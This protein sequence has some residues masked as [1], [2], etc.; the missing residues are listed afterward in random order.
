MYELGL[1]FATSKESVVDC[2]IRLL[3]QAYDAQGSRPT[4]TNTGCPDFGNPKALLKD[5][6]GEYP[7]KYACTSCEP[8]SFE[9]VEADPEP[10]AKRCENEWVR[11]NG[12][13]WDEVF[14]FIY[15][16]TNVRSHYCDRQK[17]LLITTETG[18]VW[19]AHPGYYIIIEPGGEITARFAL[20]KCDDPEPEV[21]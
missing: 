1:K 2:A 7:D 9:P 10:E 13:N 4:C 20:D 11:W 12:D 3:R 17:K 15:K 16:A 18:A 5:D 21:E 19:V 14:R 8:V 6:S